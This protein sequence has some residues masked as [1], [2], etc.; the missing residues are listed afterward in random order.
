MWC[1][2]RTLEIGSSD[3]GISRLNCLINDKGII[4]KWCQN[5]SVYFCKLQLTFEDQIL[6][7]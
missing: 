2:L 4:V 5:A 1:L 7:N 3:V 6:I